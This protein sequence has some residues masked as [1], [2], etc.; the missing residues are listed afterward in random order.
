MILLDYSQVIFAQLHVELARNHGSVSQDML[1]HFVLNKIGEYNTKF[2]RKYGQMV[3]CI[4]S[5]KGYWRK[6]AF[7]FYKWKRAKNR[8]ESDLDWDELFGYMNVI[9]DELEDKVPFLTFQVPRYE[10]DDLISIIVRN[11][12]NERHIIVSSDGDF[13]QLQ[14][15]GHVDQWSPLTKKFIKQEDPDFYR[16]DHIIR[17]DAGDG[18]PNIY[19]PADF[20]PRKDA[21]EFKKQASVYANKVEDMYRRYVSGEPLSQMLTEEQYERFQQNEMLIDLTRPVDSEYYCEPIVIEA[22]YDAVEEHLSRRYNLYGFMMKNRMR[23]L[24]ENLQDFQ[25]LGEY[26]KRPEQG[27]GTLNGFFS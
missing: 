14:K 24:M 17:G 8:E 2:K 25:N 3:I 19:S 4:D 26:P 18:I 9:R 12:T 27:D 13:A 7:E 21:G 15:F 1:R 10:A 6:K 5:R 16:F 11:F 22:L 20:F 23:M